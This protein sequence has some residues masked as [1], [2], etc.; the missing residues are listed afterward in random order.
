VGV[1][2]NMYTVHCTVTEDFLNL[3]EVFLTPTGIFLCFFLSFK[4]NARVITRKDGA[5]PALYQIS[6]ICFFRLLF[7]S[8]YILFLCKCVLLPCDNPI[9]VNK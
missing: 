4:A 7:V 1:F 6:C 5:R 2:G 9:A 8:F 3:P